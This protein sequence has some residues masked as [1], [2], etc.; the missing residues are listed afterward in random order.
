MDSHICYTF[1][2]LFV[3]NI[4]D[5][6]FVHVTGVESMMILINKIDIDDIDLASS[7]HLYD[8]PFKICMVD[9][10]IDPISLQHRRY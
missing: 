1:G 7:F 4:D 9:V 8:G 3:I 6:F 10:D 5:D 2:M